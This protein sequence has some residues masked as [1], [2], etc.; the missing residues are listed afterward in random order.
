MDALEID[1]A[2]LA[3]AINTEQR[4]SKTSWTEFFN[5]IGRLLPSASFNGLSANRVN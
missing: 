2:P 5:G 1:A 4:D 3:T